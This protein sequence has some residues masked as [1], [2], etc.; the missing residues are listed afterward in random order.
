MDDL[1]IEPQRY[2]DY[3]LW[4]KERGSAG[5]VINSPKSGQGPMY[6]HRADCDH[7]KPYGVTSP[8]ES[9]YKIKACS[10]NPGSLAVWT[11]AHGGEL[12]YCDTCR[13]GWLR[14]QQGGAAR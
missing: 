9:G 8:G 6:W 2:D 3:E 7:F 1:V 4:L 14:E 10:L 5:Y 12:R 11:V 13:P